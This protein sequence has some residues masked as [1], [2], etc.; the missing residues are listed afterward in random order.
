MQN[1][2]KKVLYF[3]LGYGVTEAVLAEA[4]KLGAFVR[5]ASAHKPGDTLEHADEVHGA[6]PPEYKKVEGIKTVGP[7]LEGIKA[8]TPVDTSEADK[9][10]AAAKAKADAEAAEKAAK[11]EA[12][13]LAAKEAA[14][15]EA[16]AAQE[17]ADAQAAKDAAAA[18]GDKTKGKK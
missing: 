16:K 10:A 8:A 5:N 11:D 13:A 1:N 2:T 6:Y 9:A 3:V 7:G 17:A 12:D 18:A 14:E 15:A 4:K